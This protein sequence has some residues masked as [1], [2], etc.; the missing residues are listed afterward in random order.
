[1]LGTHQQGGGGLVGASGSQEVLPAALGG[2]VSL[3]RCED[4]GSH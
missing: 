2:G 1:M 4:G 3:P